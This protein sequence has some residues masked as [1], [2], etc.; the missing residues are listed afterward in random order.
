MI[1]VQ[2][3]PNFFIK[4]KRKIAYGG[5]ESLKQ[6]SDKFGLEVEPKLGLSCGYITH[7]LQNA[8]L[9]KMSNIIFHITISLY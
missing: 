9:Y 6:E 3:K 4:F 5:E 2:F 7:Y 1:K 8:M